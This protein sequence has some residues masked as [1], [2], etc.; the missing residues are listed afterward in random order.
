VARLVADL[1]RLR[2][3]A[4]LASA[5]G[6]H[7]LRLAVVVA[8]TE[9]LVERV[10]LPRAYWAVVAAA[11]VLRPEFGATFTRGA[12]RVLGTCAGVVVASLIAVAIDPSGWAIVV[13]VGLLAWATYAVFPAS[14]AAGIAGLTGIVVFLLHAVAPDSAQIALDRG[15][16]TAIGGAIGLLAYALWPTWSGQSLGRLL[17][18]VVGAQRRYLNAVIAA[19]REGRLLSDDELRPLA[20]SAR[21][22]YGDAEGAVTLARSEPV[23]GADPETAAAI[24]GGLRRLVFAVHSLRIEAAAGPP[25]VPLPAL[26]PLADGFDEALERTAAQLVEGHLDRPLPKLRPLYREALASV[27]DDVTAAIG[28][29]LDELVDAIDTVASTAGLAVS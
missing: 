14:F 10:A 1:R 11:T 19:L 24:R 13:I 27:A 12:E 22:A 20:R 9:L 8:G 6:R 17:A 26:A 15:I 23:R 4:T 7:A 25:A 21:I 5:S 2:A 28:R 18:A 16:D 29:P 3:N